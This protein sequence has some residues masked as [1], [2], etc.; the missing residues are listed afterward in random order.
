[1]GFPIKLFSNLLIHLV[2][3]L[4]LVDSMSKV[5]DRTGEAADR[6]SKPVDRGTK[7]LIG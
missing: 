5:A 3:V 7:W 4:R 6:M 2:E 1:M